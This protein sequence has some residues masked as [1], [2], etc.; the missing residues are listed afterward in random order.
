MM[1]QNYLQGVNLYV[2]NVPSQ[3]TTEDLFNL[4]SSQF[5]EVL[6]CR[7]LN[8][9]RPDLRPFGFVRL[10]DAKLAHELV[11]SKY[12]HLPQHRTS[13]EIQYARLNRSN[14]PPAP[15]L[16][17]AAT[18]S[19][20]FSL[21]ASSNNLH[22]I[23]IPVDVTKDEL[24]SCFPSSTYGIILGAKIQPAKRENDTVTVA[25]MRM[26]TH[27]MALKIVA[28]FHGKPLPI[29][30]H[31]NNPRNRLIITFAFDSQNNNWRDK[32]RYLQQKSFISQVK[33]P[34][35]NSLTASSQSFIGDPAI[36]HIRLKLPSSPTPL[37]TT[38]SSSP[39]PAV[40]TLPQAVTLPQAATLPQT[41]T[42]PAAAPLAPSPPLLAAPQQTAAPQPPP[43]QQ[44]QTPKQSQLQP[45]IVEGQMEGQQRQQQQQQQPLPFLKEDLL[46]AKDVLAE[47][48][49][50]TNLGPAP[51]YADA[52]TH[53]MLAGNGLVYPGSLQQPN[54]NEPPIFCLAD[55]A[56]GVTPESMGFTNVATVAA[57]L[58][59]PSEPAVASGSTASGFI[60][61]GSA[62]SVP[63]APAPLPPPLSATSW[64][65]RSAMGL[66]PYAMQLYVTYLNILTNQQHQAAAAAAAA[67]LA[68][69]QA[70][71]LPSPSSSTT[72]ATTND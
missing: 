18:S 38:A 48:G 5:G 54:P 60:A 2:K 28:D 64:I 12:L 31:L 26:E 36:V 71:P 56:V 45:E 22:I 66:S 39:P 29:E 17:Y 47:R 30:R 4:F 70:P 44:P 13:L 69:Q 23:G 68:A 9:S 50:C 58:P 49:T 46:P 63:P 65:P 37:P 51:F 35:V 3:M 21:P 34:L 10:M 59:V 67:T 8:A 40:S 7:V 41:A 57:P 15:L 72:L 43:P 1:A 11:T 32:E 61:S 14:A 16:A 27:K 6:G 62:V 52:N 25:M 42:L 33:P 24:F 53:W 20:S 19:S 55:E